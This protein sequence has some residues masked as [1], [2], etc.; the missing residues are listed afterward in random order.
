M[1]TERNTI[2]IFTSCNAGYL[3]YI[4]TLMM[5]LRDNMPSREIRVFVLHTESPKS[6]LELLKKFGETIHIECVPVLIDGKKLEN[7]YELK[8][9]TTAYGENPYAVEGMFMCLPNRDLP[10]D[11]DR[12]L[13]LDCGD[14]VVSG[15][16]SEFYF[17]DFSG[18]VITASKGFSQNWS[19]IPEQLFDRTVYLE[20]AQEY[21]NAG[22]V[23]FNVELMRRYG[24]DFDYYFSLLNRLRKIQ[25][26]FDAPMFFKDRHFV[27]ID[28]QGLLGTAFTG[29]INFYDPDDRGEFLTYYNFRPFVLECNQ[30]LCGN[31]VY[32]YSLSDLPVKIIHLL[33]NKPGTPPE[34]RKKLLRISQ[35]CLAL[36][37]KYEAMASQ[38]SEGMG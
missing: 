18:A 14:V 24:I 2:N 11:V 8:K 12:A 32:N 21:F 31:E 28:D 10:Y 36:W 29:H 34:K 19:Y 6:N 13:Y 20:T 23:L 38:V 22:S 1:A 5:S 27:V 17:S 25:K 30:T 37:D 26:N 3:R 16:I 35:E 33:G 15:D 4:P 7:Y 9:A